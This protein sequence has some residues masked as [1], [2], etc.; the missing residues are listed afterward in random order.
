MGC[1][2]NAPK[3]AQNIP[4]VNKW[5]TRTDVTL[6][7]VLRSW[8]IIGDGVGFKTGAGRARYCFICWP[9]HSG[10]GWVSDLLLSPGVFRNLCRG[11]R[12]LGQDVSDH[13]AARLGCFFF[14]SAHKK[15]SNETAT[16]GELDMMKSRI[17]T[18]DHLV[19]ATCA[20]S[21][22]GRREGKAKM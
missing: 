18:R 2:S 3:Y 14:T 13:S 9:C 12:I 10:L 11:D 5:C 15:D 19:A 1:I 4:S 22:A 17:G 6:R 8:D 21:A 7:C 16:K 20:Q